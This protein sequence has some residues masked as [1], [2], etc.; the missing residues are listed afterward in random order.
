[1]QDRPS[2]SQVRQPVLLFCVL[3]HTSADLAMCMFLCVGAVTHT[4]H[5]VDQPMLLLALVRLRSKSTN[6]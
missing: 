3:E 2:A 6:S 4:A 1:M 5:F